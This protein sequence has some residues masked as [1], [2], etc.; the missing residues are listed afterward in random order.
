MGWCRGRTGVEQEQGRNMAEAKQE[1]G[2]SLQRVG[3]GQEQVRSSADHSRA[4]QGRKR[5]KE[6]SCW[7]D[8]G[9]V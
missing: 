9:N 2:R 6:G 5:Q 3:A 7:V 1:Q 8:A 4:E